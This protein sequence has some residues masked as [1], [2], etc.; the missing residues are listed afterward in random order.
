MNSYLDPAVH[1]TL[2]R[3]QRRLV[4]EHPGVVVTLVKGARQAISECKHQFK[5]K[6]WNCPTQEFNQGRGLFGKITDKGNYN[7]YLKV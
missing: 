6:R 3:K 5:N 4:R 2:R 1:A 7:H